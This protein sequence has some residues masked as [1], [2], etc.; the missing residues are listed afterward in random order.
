MFT[1]NS[2]I[3]IDQFGTVMGGPTSALIANNYHQMFKH[4]ATIN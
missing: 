2:T 3:T 4:Q 1:G